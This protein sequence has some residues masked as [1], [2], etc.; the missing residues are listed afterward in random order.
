[1]DLEEIGSDNMGYIHVVQNIVQWWVFVSIVMN[2][3][4]P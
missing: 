1:V 2:L 3:P 4:V